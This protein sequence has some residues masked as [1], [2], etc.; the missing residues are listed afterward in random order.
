[1]PTPNVRSLELTSEQLLGPLVY[2]HFRRGRPH[3]VGRSAVGLK[4]PF[5]HLRFEPGDDLRVY[6]VADARIAAGVERDLIRQLK[7]PH[8]DPQVRAELRAIQ[9]RRR[10]EEA[11]RKEEARVRALVRAELELPPDHDLVVRSSPTGPVRVQMDAGR[12]RSSVEAPL[13]G[14]RLDH[15]GRRPGDPDGFS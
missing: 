2:L 8:A 1:V 5:E 6:Y 11:Q 9:K 4:R 10:L 15:P 13:G 7:P 12:P 14:P 3:Y